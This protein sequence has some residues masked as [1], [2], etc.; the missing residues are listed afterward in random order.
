MVARND[1]SRD[2]LIAITVTIAAASAITTA[3]TPPTA[4]SDVP[5]QRS[6]A[7][8]DE[9]RRGSTTNDITKLTSTTTISG[10]TARPTG[11]AVV[12][13]T[14]CGISAGSNSCA[15]VARSRSA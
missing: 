5:P 2:Q 14:P 9:S 12:P 15:V 7:R 4:D 10:S 11:G 1:G 8:K 13:C 6:S 3:H